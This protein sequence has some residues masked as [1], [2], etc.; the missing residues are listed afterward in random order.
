M[1][2]VSYV[3][4]YPIEIKE[5]NMKYFASKLLKNTPEQ[6]KELLDKLNQSRRVALF[7]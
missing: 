3:G 4:K 5:L 7:M 1:K 2:T 6:N